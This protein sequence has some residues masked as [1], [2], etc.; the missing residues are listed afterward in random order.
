[1]LSSCFS[2]F[3]KIVAATILVKTSQLQETPDEIK[4]VKYNYYIQYIATGQRT[5]TCTDVIH[6]E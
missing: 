3:Q 1:M 2:C 4:Y 5:L 6:S